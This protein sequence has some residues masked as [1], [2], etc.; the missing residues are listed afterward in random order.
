VRLATVA[1]PVGLLLH[2]RERSGYVN[3][4]EL[5]GDPR[6]APLAEVLG[7]G[8]AAICLG[9]IYREY[10]LEDGQ[11]A[12][13]WPEAFVCGPGSVLARPRTSSSPRSPTGSTAR[14]NSGSLSE[15]PTAPYRSARPSTP[16][17]DLSS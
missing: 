17:R 6:F 4:G 8:P 1:T 3:L 12:P 11:Q 9:L 15:R 2:V 13:T 16:L 10:T 14:G 7:T 5:T